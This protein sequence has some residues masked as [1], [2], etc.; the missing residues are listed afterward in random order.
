MRSFLVSGFLVL[1]LMAAG[2]MALAQDATTK[3]VRFVQNG[4]TGFGILDGATI[5]MLDGDPIKGA[6]TTGKTVALDSVELLPPS[7]AG[8]VFRRRDEFCQPYVF[9]VRPPAAAVP[10]AADLPDRQW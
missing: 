9:G 10:E 2:P 5:A 3:Y 1:G 6:K 8:K 4:Q 7:D